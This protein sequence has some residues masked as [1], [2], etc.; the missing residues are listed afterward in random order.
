MGSGIVIS[1]ALLVG[2]GCAARD[3][4]DASVADDS[5]AVD[6]NVCLKGS[7]VVSAASAEPYSKQFVT[8]DAE[9]GTQVA[10]KVN[11]R[12]PFN[13]TEFAFSVRVLF[14][15]P[16][17]QDSL[18]LDPA[19]VEACRG[20]IRVLPGAKLNLGGVT[21][22]EFIAWF[23]APDP[24][25]G[26]TC[27]LKDGAKLSVSVTPQIL[28]H[29]FVSTTER[30]NLRARPNT[31]SSVLEVVPKEAPLTLTGKTS[32]D[33]YSV[34]R[35]DKR[36]WVSQL[37]VTPLFGTAVTTD[38]LNL[39]ALPS[40]EGAI[41]TVIPANA[42]VLLVGGGRTVHERHVRRTH[43]YVSGRFLRDAEFGGWDS[44]IGEARGRRRRA[45]CPSSTR[46]PGHT[47]SVVVTDGSK[48]QE[49]AAPAGRWRRSLRARGLDGLAVLGAHVASAL[50]LP[51]PRPIGVR[52]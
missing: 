39:R 10:A 38:R 29:G 34:V 4:D 52:A 51:A 24:A 33:F 32:G 18:D 23:C 44:L 5:A 37:Y 30:L 21:D 49:A 19:F 8:Y 14:E 16:G 2:A 35:G 47:V 13:P 15:D 31:Q 1:M 12:V 45:R 25:R 28:T 43:G 42:P 17:A 48:P 11:N 6:V 22:P 46:A 7:D 20:S 40:V 27:D 3:D 9:R 50:T 36:G 41:R 26:D